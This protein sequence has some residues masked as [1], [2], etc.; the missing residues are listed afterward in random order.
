MHARCSRLRPDRSSAKVLRRRPLIKP[1][2]DGI[3]RDTV[4]RGA[5]GFTG[6]HLHGAR[7][8]S[9]RYNL[10]CRKR[11][12]DGIAR[13]QADKV[14]QRGNR[15]VENVRGAAAIC[16]AAVAKQIDL[17]GGKRILP[18]RGAQSDLVSRPDQQRT[19]QAVRGD[20]VGGGELPLRKNR[21]N[22][23]ESMRDPIH[24]GQQRGLIHL[25]KG[26]AGKTE[27]NLGLDA[28]LRQSSQRQRDRV[29]Q[30]MP[31]EL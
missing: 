12:I 17:E 21:L 27:Y 5:P 31:V 29:A 11:R 16:H 23:F 7:E 10:A 18:L 24:A 1:Q 13:Q 8:R 19:M 6:L 20:R 4:E 28:W 14:T 26:R 3:Q 9:C 25:R 30:I 22:D 15:S 2:P